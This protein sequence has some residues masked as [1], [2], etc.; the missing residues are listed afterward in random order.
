MNK[1]KIKNY[2]YILKLVFYQ[3]MNA[4]IEI[5]GQPTSRGLRLSI[6]EADW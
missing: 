4:N 5:I 1:N 2:L 6:P 3:I